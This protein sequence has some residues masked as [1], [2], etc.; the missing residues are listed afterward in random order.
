MPLLDLKTDLKSL[1]YG[2]DRP[3]G[4]DS[5]LPYITTDINNIDG[6]SNRTQVG[7]LI[8]KL[9]FTKFDDGLVR[10]GIIGALNSSVVDTLRIGK[11]FLDAPRG[12]L[13]ITKQIG[14]QLSNPKLESKQ[15]STNNPTVGQ[16]FLNNVGNLI[17]NVANTITNTVGPTRIYNLGVNT[18][19]QVPLNAFG[20]HIVRHGLLPVQT[21][22]SKYIKVVAFNNENGTNRLLGLTT[23]FQLGN[24][25]GI[26]NINTTTNRARNFLGN[27]ATTLGINIRGLKPEQLV[28]AEYKGGPGSV[29]GIL[30]STTINRTLQVTNDLEKIKKATEQS[31]YYAGKTRDSGGAPASI[32]Y[33]SGL[34]TGSKSISSY[35]DIV[36]VPTAIDQNV[37]KY[38]INPAIKR[39]TELMSQIDTQ[40]TNTSIYT[41]AEYEQDKLTGRIRSLDS[42]L[43]YYTN[44]SDTHYSIKTDYNDNGFVKSTLEKIVDVTKQSKVYKSGSWIAEGVAF[45][46]NFVD[47]QPKNTILDGKNNLTALP[48]QFKYNTGSLYNRTNDTNVDDDTLALVFTPINPFSLAE[49]PKRFRAYLDDYSETYD[50]SW[51]DI[52][53]TGRAESFYIFNSFKRTAAI[54]LFIPCFNKNELIKNHDDLFALGKGGLAYALAGQYSDKNLLG[55][56]ITKVTV[57]NYLVQTPGIITSLNVSIPKESP[58]SL[59]YKYA[60]VLKLTFA[61]TIIG[62]SVPMY[63]GVTTTPTTPPPTPSPSPTPE[64]DDDEGVNVVS[65]DIRIPERDH[66][67]VKKPP[68]YNFTTG[69]YNL[70][71]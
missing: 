60:H 43:T 35:F 59:K 1:K 69:K 63:E 23:K 53:Y 44:T 25:E 40:N 18:L 8:T 46:E 37:V 26:V 51:G 47:R 15:L 41:H 38:N 36:D 4:G 29:Y 65:T 30:G 39:Y 62:S 2:S 24:P 50:S 20:G 49:T 12:P 54:G 71:Q 64:D 70:G 22:D 19:L 66:T 32:N 33:T 27:L 5:G 17:T 55:G 57:G 3:G 6:S 11:F 68:V 52:K 9:R 7:R 16:G 13:F 58:W 42:G 10:G 31:I 21:E 61:F 34:G 45:K 28:I 14:L 67:Y 56:I 48:S